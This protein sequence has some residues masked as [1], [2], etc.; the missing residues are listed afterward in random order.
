[1]FLNGRAGHFAA[2]MLALT[3]AACGDDKKSSPD[4]EP[5]LD[6]GT[7][8]HSDAGMDASRGMDAARSDARIPT[9]TDDGAVEQES[10]GAVKTEE[11]A[12]SG[13]LDA[14]QPDAAQQQ[15]QPDAAPNTPADAGDASSQI[16][17]DAALADAAAD[18]GTSDAAVHC[19]V[20]NALFGCGTNLG[21]GWVKFSN[22]LE[23]DRKNHLAW[24]PVFE[25]SGPSQLEA[26]CSVLALGPVDA[27]V[28]P[29]IADLR[30]LAAGC[31]ETTA[32]AGP[33][34]M[35]KCAVTSADIAVDV[36]GDCTCSGGTGP[37]DGKF[38]KAEVPTC[39]TVWTR[40][41][42]GPGCDQDARWFY[43]VSTGSIV[44]STSDTDLAHDAKA[45]CVAY[46]NGPQ[47]PL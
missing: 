34:P 4:D 20:N 22:G 7:V 11:D 35:G 9:T 29:D 43:D 24:S 38:C 19:D 44:L 32:F 46:I 27:F 23:I 12:A 8:V 45:R 37:H 39:E 16:Q 5:E 28:V 6:S 1:M 10:D 2:A 40:T 31:N 13:T 47:L 30:T 33:D 36:A 18:G 25:F 15:G 21:D 14:A 41:G 42:C 17:T 26:T 3:V